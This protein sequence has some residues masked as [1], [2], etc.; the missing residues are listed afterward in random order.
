MVDTVRDGG[1]VGAHLLG[2]SLRNSAIACDHRV[3]AIAV[4][5]G[6]QPVLADPQRS[7]LCADVADALVGD[8]DVRGDDRVDFRIELS[9]LEELHRRQ[10]Q[11]LLLDGGRRSRKAARHRAAD[12][13]PMAGVGEPAEYLAGAPD[14]HGEAHVHQMR[15][16]E[17][18][19]VDD[20]DVAF[21]RRQAA[22]V[23]DHLDDCLRR[24]LHDADEDR[25]ALRPLRDQRTVYGRVD[26]VGAV[27]RLGYDRREGGSAEGQVH[28]VAGLL[29]RGLDD[30]EGD[31][32]EGHGLPTSIRIFPSASP[33]ATSPGSSTVVASI[34][35]RI[36]GPSTTASRGNFS[37]T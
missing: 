23:S 9:P 25:Q 1:D 3:V 10:A 18:G 30:G 6:E 13:G 19:V 34:C 28:L 11:A 5:D 33:R 29:E 35:S 24:I 16:A 26:A 36:A 20:V 32:V 14:R 27:V 15:A 7:R 22:S 37:L 8:A 4:E 31:G 12:V 2:G 17:I 21:L